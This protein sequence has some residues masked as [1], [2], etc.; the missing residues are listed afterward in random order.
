MQLYEN[1]EGFMVLM[2]AVRVT[3]F[4]HLIVV[5]V[6]VGGVDSYTQRGPKSE[7]GERGLGQVRPKSRELP[8]WR[9]QIHGQ[10]SHAPMNHCTCGHCGT[11]PWDVEPCMRETTLTC[12]GSSL[13]RKQLLPAS[14]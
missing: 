14:K 2:G 12:S 10:S 11:W 4:M 5:W 13:A 9:A 6:Q 7:D 3:F 8:I 1:E